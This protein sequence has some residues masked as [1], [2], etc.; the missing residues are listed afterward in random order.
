[1][2]ISEDKNGNIWVTTENKG[3][4][5]LS[6]NFAKPTSLHKEYFNPKNHNYAVND[7]IYIYEDSKRNIWATSNS[8]GLFRLNKEKNQFDNMNKE[9]HWDF[10]RIFSIMEDPQ[11]RLWLTADDALICLW[12]DM[13]GQVQYIYTSEN[14]LG[15]MVF[16]P[17]S[18]FQMGS[19]LY[20]GSG[21]NVISVN[22]AEARM[23][24]G[25]QLAISLLPISS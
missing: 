15:D 24:R 17:S 6:G 16:M 1:M 4:L 3:I 22:T 10:D 25:Y 14:G 9:L 11:H 19:N 13:E 23:V 2:N 12:F 7:A 18:C 5:R 8:G 21:R 20:F